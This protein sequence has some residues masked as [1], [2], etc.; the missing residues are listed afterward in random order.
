MHGA[1]WL[2]KAWRG[3]SHEQFLQHSSWLHALGW[4]LPAAVATV[5]LVLR[6]VEADELTSKAEQ[7]S[8]A[9]THKVKQKKNLFWVYLVLR[10]AGFLV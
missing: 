3:C 1:C 7:P 2:L 8:V 6:K 4:G 9:T 5:C 10:V